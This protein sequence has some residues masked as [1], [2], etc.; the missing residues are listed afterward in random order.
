LLPGSLDFLRG[1]AISL[2]NK[3]TISL[4]RCTNF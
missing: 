2:E 1:S 4:E 3:P